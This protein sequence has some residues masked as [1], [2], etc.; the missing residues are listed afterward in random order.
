MPEWRKDP[1]V[2]RWV[3]VSTERAKRPTDYRPPTEL[4]K[5]ERCPLCEG[6]EGDTP[7]EVLAFRKTGGERDL[8]GWWVR[9]VP[10]KFPACRV[11]EENRVAFEGVNVKRKGVGAH[12]VIVETTDHEPNLVNQTE[13][14]VQEVIWAWRQ[15]SLALREDK[16]LKY[17][18]I[19][20]N[21][22]SVAG[23]SLEHAHSQLIAL[24][25]VPVEIAAEIAGVRA[26]REAKGSCVYCDLWR[27][28][29]AAGDRVVIEGDEF[30]SFVPY[31]AR[32]PFEMWIV[33]K[34]HQADFGRI[35]EA[36]VRDL[37][38]VVRDSLRRL[39]WTVYDPPFNMVLHTCPVNDGTSDE[40]HWHI[41]ILPRLTIIAGFELGT[42]YYINPTPPELAAAAL[43]ES[44]EWCPELITAVREVRAGV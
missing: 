24:P 25:M 28:E 6:N 27:H 23:S 36:E 39:A 44:G 12:E 38:S 21:K 17:I 42:G 20:K 35:N 30:L 18:S 1:V 7:P 2:D 26:Y 5:Q 9:V 16:R 13:W 43:R 10:N 33:P 22:G 40:Y 4:K 19:F 3:A 34:R 15:R 11:E 32:F 14:Q 37:A 31:A 8:P 29:S 41:E